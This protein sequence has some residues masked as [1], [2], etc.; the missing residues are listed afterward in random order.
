MANNLKKTLSTMFRKQDNQMGFPG[1]TS[2]LQMPKMS[3]IICLERKEK[4]NS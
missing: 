1:W 4:F 3:S 2:T